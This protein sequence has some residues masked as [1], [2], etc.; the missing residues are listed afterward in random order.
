MEENLWTL[1]YEIAQKEDLIN[2]KLFDAQCMLEDLQAQVDNPVIERTFAKN[3]LHSEIY[4]YMQEKLVRAEANLALA[5]HESGH[6]LSSFYKKSNNMFSMGLSNR[7]RDFK[8]W[9]NGDGNH[10]AGWHDWRSSIDDMA[11]WQKRH[12]DAGN[13]DTT[14]N[15]SY[16]ESLRGVGYATDP[17][18]EYAVKSVYRRL[19]IDWNDLLTQPHNPR[20]L[21]L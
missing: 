13:I 6:F 14:S 16:I 19:F 9:S 2:Q 18:H 10:K 15:L 20:N 5:A 1:K 17:N 4:E 12:I 3:S 21:N 8:V 7:P 11:K